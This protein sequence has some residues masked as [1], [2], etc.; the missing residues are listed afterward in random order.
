MEKELNSAEYLRDL[1]ERLMRVP[2]MY[3][4]DQSDVSR[5]YEIARELEWQEN[6]LSDP[7]RT[8]D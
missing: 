1:A 4:T 2:V 8:E 5:L 6:N 3:G 7:E